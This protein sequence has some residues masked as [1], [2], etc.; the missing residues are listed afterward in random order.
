MLNA[1]K[2]LLAPPLIYRRRDGGDSYE[3][4]HLLSDRGGNVECG[5]KPPPSRAR[6]SPRGP[7]PGATD[8]LYEECP[9]SFSVVA[10]QG[11]GR[12]L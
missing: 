11:N 5:G 4:G 6:A 7:G 2:Y 8:R 3:D 9:F 1:V 12:F 10:R